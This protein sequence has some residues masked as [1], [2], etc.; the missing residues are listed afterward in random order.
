MGLSIGDVRFR[1]LGGIVSKTV[2]DLFTSAILL[3]LTIV[4]MW[5]AAQQRHIVM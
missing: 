2:S 5:L 1:F 3:N 4:Y